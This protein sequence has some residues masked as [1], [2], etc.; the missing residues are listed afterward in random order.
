[1]LVDHGVADSIELALP[2]RREIVGALLAQL[3]RRGLGR[4]F[5]RLTDDE[6]GGP[7]DRQREGLVIRALHILVGQICP[8]PAA[9]EGHVLGNQF[10]P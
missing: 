5:A 1:M 3:E 8:R 6:A 4:V 7:A 9:D 10:L 2:S